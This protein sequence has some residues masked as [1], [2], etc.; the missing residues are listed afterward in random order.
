M[1]RAPRFHNTPGAGSQG[2][3]AD[4]RP[5]Q[6]ASPPCGSFAVIKNGNAACSA[7]AYLE[8]P[9]RFFRPLRPEIV[10]SRR[11]VPHQTID[12]ARGGDFRRLLRRAILR[13]KFAVEHNQDTG[14]SG[15][16]APL[17]LNPHRRRRQN[18]PA[19]VGLVVK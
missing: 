17:I 14:P 15:A 18:W 9:L 7:L 10:I 1:R 5:A 11:V 16:F 19:G 13:Q 2:Y 3:P 4:L 8:M 6:L 12:E